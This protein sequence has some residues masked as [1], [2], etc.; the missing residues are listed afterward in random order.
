MRLALRAALVLLAL[1]CSEGE[2]V[3]ALPPATPPAA[4]PPPQV[5]S[6]TRAATRLAGLSTEVRG[7]VIR[8]TTAYVS[9]DYG[10]FRIFDVSGPPVLLGW[11]PEVVG[12]GR[13]VSVDGNTVWLASADAGVLAIDVSDPRAPR[14]V[15]AVDLPGYTRHAVVRGARAYAAD[16]WSGFAMLDVTDR[17]RPLALGSLSE[18]RPCFRVAPGW[19]PTGTVSE[20]HVFVA[21]GPNGVHVMDVSGDI[22]VLTTTLDTPGHA[23]DVLLDGNVLYVADDVGGVR[24]YDAGRAEAPRLVA[25]TD[26]PGHARSLAAVTLAD[27]RRRLFVADGSAGLPTPDP[28]D[29]G[30][31]PGEADG[32]AGLVRLDITNPAAPTIDGTADTAGYALTLEADA[33]QV[34]VAVNSVGLL[35]FDPESLQHQ[36]TFAQNPGWSHAVAPTVN[37]AFLS[38]QSKDGSAWLRAVH[39]AEVARPVE[40]GA[41]ALPALATALVFAEQTA[42]V[43]AAAGSLIGVDVSRPAAPVIR[44]QVALDG[45]RDLALDG[46]SLVVAHGA[47]LSRRALDDPAALSAF[48]PPLG[49]AVSVAVDGET[50]VATTERLVLLAPDGAVLAE[51]AVDGA[52]AVALGQHAV[53]TRGRNGAL[54]FARDLSGTPVEITTAGG[55]LHGVA[56]VG[57]HAFFAAFDPYNFQTE[58]GLRVLDLAET[59]PREQVFLHLN[60]PLERVVIHATE[61]WVAASTIG[62]QRI[63]VGCANA[64]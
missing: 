11:L 8:G 61:A 64:Q 59:P 6:C 55:A 57:T 48:G 23:W 21:G 42:T 9:D 39:T 3:A 58:S 16:D 62:L 31:Y 32:R 52:V 10:G 20:K 33:S 1:S 26:T 28:P 51:R 56:L 12:L 44:S 36:A 2:E 5:L 24:V 43:W 63:S 7:V 25:E 18:V 34:L 19:G 37:W 40:R 15:G 54:V 53:V 27:G 45:A 41:V 60:G 35:V 38:T 17:T 13:G 4:L 14:L 30:G 47:G 29:P 46:D 49:P 50:L 22:P